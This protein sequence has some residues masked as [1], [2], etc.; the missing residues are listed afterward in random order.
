MARK[1]SDSRGRAKKQRKPVSED[2]LQG[3]PP[4]EALLMRGDR[5]RQLEEEVQRFPETGPELTAGDLDADWKRAASSG[6][7]TP[8]GSVATPDQ[9][10][11]DDIGQALGVPRAP[12]EEVR[13][14]QEILEGRDRHR[15]EQEE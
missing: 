14:S 8:G 11:V 15:W 1:K 10:R 5:E 13:T 2:A 12:D 7:E 4:R 6:E 9:D 3:S